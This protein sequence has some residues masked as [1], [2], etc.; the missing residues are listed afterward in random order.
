MA[1]L[2]SP[3]RG[4]YSL[5]VKLGHNLGDCGRDL[6]MIG[7]SDGGIVEGHS[8]DVQEVCQMLQLLELV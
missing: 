5:V 4:I 8:M 6:L 3:V 2:L 1:V 7:V